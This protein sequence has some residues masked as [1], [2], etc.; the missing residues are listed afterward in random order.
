MPEMRFV[1]NA[2]DVEGLVRG[3][4]VNPTKKGYTKMLWSV[5]DLGVQSDA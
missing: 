3:C 2:D 1:N 5:A 4:D